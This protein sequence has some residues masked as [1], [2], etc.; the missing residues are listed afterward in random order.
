MLTATKL[1]R[2]VTYREKLS[3]IKLDNHLI[4]WSLEI[5]WRIKNAISPTITMPEAT[6]LTHIPFKKWFREFT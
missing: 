6:K 4:T 1:G 3:L 5:M 2:K